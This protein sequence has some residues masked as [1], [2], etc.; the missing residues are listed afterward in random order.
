MMQESMV[1]VYKYK[2]HMRGG[3]PAGVFCAPAPPL[4]RVHR[5]VS[6]SDSCFDSTCTLCAVSLCMHPELHW[7]NTP[8]QSNLFKEL[9]CKK[10]VGGGHS[11]WPTSMGRSASSEYRAMTAE[12]N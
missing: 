4:L 5:P 10:P 3:G 12:G 2:A 6:D 11:P 9:T 8:A 7:S 1:I